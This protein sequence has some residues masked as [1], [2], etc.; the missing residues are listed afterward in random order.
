[1]TKK[2]PSTLP[3]I[4]LA[5]ALMMPSASAI[6]LLS[7]EF[8]EDDQPEF[9]LWPGTIFGNRST[10]DFATDGEATSGTTTVIVDT[11]S[12]FGAPANRGS[13]DGNPIGYSFQ[14]LYEDLLHATGPTGFLTL[15]FSGLNPNQAYRFTLYAWDP[16]ASNG[17]DKVWTVT[18]GSG[19]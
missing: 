12:G 17:S 19:N 14:H 15:T 10:V 8:R 2:T 7:I 4:I 5:A 16:G 9:D 1:M 3:A 18:D 11:S 6:T 13:V